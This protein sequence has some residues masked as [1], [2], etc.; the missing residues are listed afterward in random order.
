TCDGGTSVVNNRSA[1]ETANGLEVTGGPSYRFIA[2]LSA[3][4]G[5]GCLLA[6]QSGQ[7]GHPHYADQLS[8]WPSGQWHPLWM[9]DEAIQTEKTGEFVLEPPT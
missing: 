2:D 8:L 4:G 9:D 6:G 1:R 3:S 5:Q 7:P